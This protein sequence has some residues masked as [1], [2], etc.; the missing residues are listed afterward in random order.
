MNS[1]YFNVKLNDR[2]VL[3]TIVATVLLGNS[4]KDVLTDL[5][6]SEF[7]TLAYNDFM[8]RDTK[9]DLSGIVFTVLIFRKMSLLPYI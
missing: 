4:S 8:Y 9:Y 3:I 6:P 1:T 5:M 2:K 7:G